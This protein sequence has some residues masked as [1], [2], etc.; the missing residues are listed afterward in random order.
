MFEDRAIDICEVRTPEGIWDWEAKHASSGVDRIVPAEIPP[1]IRA[2]CLELAQRCHE[3]IGC[4]HM[5]R[6]DFRWDPDRSQ[7][8]ASS[9]G[10]ATAISGI[11]ADANIAEGL[12][13]WV[14]GG[15]S[16]LP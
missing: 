8:E 14:T 9:G 7:F 2:L 3:V 10:L 15:W 11:R 5:S 12:T 16:S 4:I 13:T 1:G 6:T